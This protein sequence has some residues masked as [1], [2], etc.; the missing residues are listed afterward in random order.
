MPIRITQIDPGSLQL[1]ESGSARLVD[2]QQFDIVLKVEGTLHETEA[3]LLEAVCRDLVSQNH[4]RIGLDLA[5]ISF[6]DSDSAAVLCRLK[7]E[8]GISLEGLHLFI[9]KVI[10]LAEEY[11]RVRAYRAEV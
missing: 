5:S 11:E 10:E 3:E 9:G 2:W 1:A 8:F 4:K 7:S 6:L